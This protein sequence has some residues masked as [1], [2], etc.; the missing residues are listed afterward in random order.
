[1][2]TTI[3]LGFLTVICLLLL[4]IFHHPLPGIHE[5][6]ITFP[7]LYLIGYF[8]AIIIGLVFL[9]YFGIRFA[10]EN[11]R[12]SDAIKQLQQVIAK[13]YELESLG[14]QAA[15]AAHSLGTPLATISITASELKKDIGSNKEISKDIDLII[16]QTKRCGDIL[17]QI[18]KKQIKED[19]F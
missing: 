7:K 16:S 18:S 9:S 12:R 17:K 19:I 6:S 3:V 15:A 1:M 10:G 13:E 2:G 8:T 11:K 4:N 14:G 5:G